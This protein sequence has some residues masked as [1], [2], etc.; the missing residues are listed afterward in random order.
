MVDEVA[1]YVAPKVVGGA[2]ALGP[3]GGEGAVRMADAL[4]LGAPRVGLLGDDVCVAWRAGEGARDPAAACVAT[5]PLGLDD[6]LAPDDS[7]TRDFG[8]AASGEAA[9]HVRGSAGRC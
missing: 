5:G 9:A 4:A 3:V 6:A 1:T 7:A 8:S 2:G